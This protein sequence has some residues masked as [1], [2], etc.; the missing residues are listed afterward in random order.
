MS[1]QST[2]QGELLLKLLAGWTLADVDCGDRWRTLLVRV[3]DVVEEPHTRTVQALLDGGYLFGKGGP[4]LRR[5]IMT[6]LGRAAAGHYRNFD[7]RR[8]LAEADRAGRQRRSR[9]AVFAVQKL[10]NATCS[11]SWQ[12]ASKPYPSE[13]ERMESIENKAF[14][15]WGL[16][17]VMGHVRYAGRITEQTIG[18]ASFIRVDVPQVGDTPALTK[19]LGSGSI[20]CITPTTEETAKALAAQICTDPPRVYDAFPSGQQ[21]RLP[22]GKEPDSE[23]DDAYYDDPD[24]DGNF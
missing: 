8:L 12:T 19:I 11:P 14:E 17:E 22:L 1:I 2:H 3:G 15:S 9:R 13:I 5:W 10:R 23:L 6:P 4:P 7:R 24:E 21:Q 18:G 20:Y 16:C